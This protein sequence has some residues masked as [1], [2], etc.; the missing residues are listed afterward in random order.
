MKNYILESAGRGKIAP[1]LVKKCAQGEAGENLIRSGITQ[2]SFCRFLVK[3]ALEMVSKGK[4]E[5]T[6]T[7]AFSMLS[8]AN[9]S[10]A[11]KA[12]AECSITFEGEKKQS[13]AAYWLS[14][15]GSKAAP[16]LSVF[17]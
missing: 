8:G 16:D 15:G 3:I 12:L 13:V 1:A 2:E 7:S 11:Q 10:A 9:A 4:D 14:I 5:S 6:I 17:D